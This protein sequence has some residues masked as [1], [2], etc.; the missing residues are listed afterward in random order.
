M[1]RPT[2]VVGDVHGCGAELAALLRLAGDCDLVLVGDIFT[3]GPQPAQVWSIIEATGAR[4]TLGNH[5]LWMLEHRATCGEMGLPDAAFDYLAALPTTLALPGALV[6][7][8]GL[9]PE[10]REAGTPRSMALHL[11]RWPDD[12]DR[13]APFWWERL[14]PGPLVIYGHD[15]ARGLQD[16]R[17][18]SLGLDSGC[19]YGGRLSGYLLEADQLLS[20]PAGGAYRPIQAGAAGLG[21][22]G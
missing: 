19:V 12:R 3:K 14:A 1:S 4:A 7:H 2:L 16:H 9:H 8:A 17:P 21:W 22:R 10:L 18:R 15:A 20:V 11:R 6:V 13:A 5:D